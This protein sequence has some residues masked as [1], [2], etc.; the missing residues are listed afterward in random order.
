MKTNS[1]APTFAV[2][3]IWPPTNARDT[4]RTDYLFGPYTADYVKRHGYGFTRFSKEAWTFPTEAQARNKARIIER[5]MYGQC[6]ASA[7]PTADL[8]ESTREPD[9]SD[10]SR[11]SSRELMNWRE[12]PRRLPVEL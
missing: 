11:E 6:I 10:V 12:L 3:V 8:P 2:Q 4:T 7:V 5:H 1:T 9:A